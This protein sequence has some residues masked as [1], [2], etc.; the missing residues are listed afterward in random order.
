MVTYAVGQ[1]IGGPLQLPVPPGQHLR[2]PIGLRPRV[3]NALMWGGWA[4]DALGL[5][6]TE[7]TREVP[8]PPLMG[9][10][11]IPVIERVPVQEAQQEIQHGVGNEELVL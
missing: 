1:A 2:A 7:G 11:R 8:A 10:F 3:G 9:M 4:M 6:M 5:A